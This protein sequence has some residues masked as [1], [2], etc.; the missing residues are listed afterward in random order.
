MFSYVNLV[1]NDIKIEENLE[2]LRQKRC[3]SHSKYKASYF[4]TN[5]S[6]LKNSTSFLC[7]FCYNNHS[8]NHLKQKEIQSVE[9]LFSTKRLTQMKEDCKIDSSHEDKI[10]KVLQD[11]DHIFKTLKINLCNIINKECKKIKV[12]IKQKFSIDNEYIMKILKKHEQVLLDVFNKDEIMNDFNLIINP[13]LE[14]F[15]KVSETFRWQI[16]M[17]EN[18]DK[19]IDLLAKNLPKINQ[20]HKDLADIVQKKISKFDALYDNIKLVNPIQS[21]K[22]NEILLQK[23]KNCKID[24]NIPRLHTD[25]INKIISYDSNRKFITCSYDKTII[26]RNSEDNT[27]IRTLTGHK[28]I[29][30]DVLLLSDG[31]LASS[32]QDKTIKIW[33]LTNGNCEQMLIGHSHWVCCLLELPNSILLSGSYDSSI[34][35][36]DISQKDL[37]ELQ[38]YQQIKRDKQSCAFCMTLINVNELAVSSS[39]NINIYSLD[40]KSFIIIKTLIGHTGWV[41]DIKPMNN[42]KDLLLSCSDDKDCRLWSISQENCLKIFKGHSNRIWTMQILSE[43][44]FVSASAEILFWNIDSAEAIHSIKPD[45]SGDIIHSLLKNV[46]NELVFA[47]QH[48]FIGLIKI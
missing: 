18:Y 10:N 3:D 1:N 13:Y 22:S 27:A 24:K 11:L 26:I 23:L 42:S 35:I 36:W 34:G 41:D 12:H 15:N 31:R 48:D 46:K 40:K 38:F 29:V 16:E 5:F 7:E 37:K 32:S 39:N 20:K 6:C 21:I 30:R 47:G 45:E 43:K 8:T 14:S 17:V 2:K 9:D 44:T 33:N 19:N 28:D 25:T 4:C